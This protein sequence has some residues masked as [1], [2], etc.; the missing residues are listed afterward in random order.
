MPDRDPTPDP[1]RGI[2]MTGESGLVVAA[3]VTGWQCTGHPSARPF[4]AAQ[5]ERPRTRD[6]SPAPDSP[7]RRIFGL[8]GHRN[9]ICRIGSYEKAYEF[10]Q[11]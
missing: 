1:S 5:G 7:Q 3:G 9:D 10:A 4:D 6:S 2:G 8:L 11:R